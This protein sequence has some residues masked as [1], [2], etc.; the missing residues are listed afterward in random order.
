[1]NYWV[2]LLAVLFGISLGLNITQ[3]LPKRKVTPIQTPV[4]HEEKAD[5]EERAKRKRQFEAEQKAFEQ[6]MNYNADVAYNM[7]GETVRTR[8]G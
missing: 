4:E 1:M 2:I 8:K 3:L 7:N 5:T 6:L